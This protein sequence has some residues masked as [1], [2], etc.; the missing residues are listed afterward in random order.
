MASSIEVDGE[1]STAWSAPPLARPVPPRRRKVRERIS[2]GH[3]FMIAAGL[4]AFVL[5]VSVLQDRT[6][7]TQVLIADAEILPGTR[8]TPD[9]VTVVDL[10]ADSDLVDSLASMADLASGEVSAGHR[11]VAGDPIT[12]T[13]L[14]PAA[15]PSGLRA[16]S[17]PVDRVDAVGGDLAAGDRVDIV[18]V[19]GGVASYIATDLEV[20]ATQGPDN[21]GGALGASALSTYY[22]TVSIDDQTALAVALAMETGDISILRST[23]AVPV[24][25]AA[26]HFPAS[27]LQAVPGPGTPG[28]GTGSSVADGAAGTPAPVD[29]APVEGGDASTV[30]AEGADNG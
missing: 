8:L 6:V 15:T 26:R 17:L 16:M 13:A 22:V 9:L 3:L 21:R 27:G 20:I 5:V 12:R 2:L 18:S 28:T 23:G 1:P 11:L 14:A 4:L 30:P 10:P 24:P 7:T 25:E 29:P 19:T